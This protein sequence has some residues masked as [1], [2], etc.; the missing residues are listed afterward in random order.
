MA[1]QLYYKGQQ[2]P[3][4]TLGGENARVMYLGTQYVGYDGQYGTYI[5]ASGGTI[6]D[7]GSWRYHLFTSSADLT[8][9]VVSL[10]ENIEVLVVGAGGGGGSLASGSNLPGGGDGGAVVYVPY[11]VGFN[12]GL[13]T[14]SVVVGSGGLGQD[15]NP[16]PTLARPSSPGNP[17]YLT[18]SGVEIYAL[19]GVD[20]SNAFISQSSLSGLSGTYGYNN[21]RGTYSISLCGS[22]GGGGA[23][24]PGTAA[25]AS[26][27]VPGGGGDGYLVEAFDFAGDWEARS[28]NKWGAGGGGNGFGCGGCA[29]S[30]NGGD[31]G[32]SG[33]GFGKGPTTPINPEA[34]NGFPNTGGGG[35]GNVGGALAGNGAAGYVAIR[36]KIA[37]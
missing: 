13:G 11:S 8:I 29:G 33:G 31:G 23:G 17:S 35:G 36:Y 28:G 3:T 10:N 14:Y 24:T 16:N 21:P 22:P 1:G 25:S 7:S 18:G 32:E 12:L 4:P 30:Y 19:G 37:P 26:L 34:V 5:S 2:I 9:D 20:P 15:G 27:C 6:Y